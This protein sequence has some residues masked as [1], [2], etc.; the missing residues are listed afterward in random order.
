MK[1]FFYFGIIS[2]VIIV[3]VATIK[4]FAFHK[5]NGKMPKAFIQNKR[6]LKYGDR[7][8]TRGIRRGIFLAMKGKKF[9]VRLDN[10]AI[11]SRS[12]IF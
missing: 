1:E 6:E 11:V 9:V 3:I 8:I 2:F 4:I 7:I 12:K 5:K 10:G